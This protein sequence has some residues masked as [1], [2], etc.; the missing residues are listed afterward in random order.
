MNW[1]PEMDITFLQTVDNTAS[2]SRL[3][4]IGAR[5]VRAY[6][7]KTGLHYQQYMGT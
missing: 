1:R 7:V 3:L 5:T 6:C 4:E 2:Y